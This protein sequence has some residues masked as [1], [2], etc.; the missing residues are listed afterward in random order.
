VFVGSAFG[1]LAAVFVGLAIIWA[2][3]YGYECC[4]NDINGKRDEFDQQGSIYDKQF[5]FS[6]ETETKF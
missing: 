2:I 5:H 1:L 3:R 6:D 4:L